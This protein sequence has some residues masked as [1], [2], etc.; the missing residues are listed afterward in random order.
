MA[1]PGDGCT[2]GDSE[3]FKG[4]L[5]ITSAD[6]ES[7]HKTRKSEFAPP[8]FCNDHEYELFHGVLRRQVDQEE[9][10]MS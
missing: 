4:A 7:K 6:I 3:A 10:P 9:M 8:C 5:R 2:A 1:Q